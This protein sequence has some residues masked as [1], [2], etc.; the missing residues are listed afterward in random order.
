M[1]S[2]RTIDVGGINVFYREAGSADAPTLLLLHGFPTS[3]AQYEGLIDRLADRFHLVAPDYPG[4]GRTYPLPGPSTFDGLADTVDGFADALAMQHYS[5]YLFD[6]GAPVGFRLATRHP[7]RVRALVIQNANAYEAG[8][9]PNL[10]GLAPYWEDRAANEPAVRAFL[11]LDSTRAQYLEGVAEPETVNPDHWTLD[12]HFQDLPGRDQVML[13]LIYDYTS[14]VALYPTWQAY[15][16]EHRPPT[17]ITWGANDRYFVADGARA[18]LADVPNAQL[19]LL[20]TG[21]FA[22]ATHVDEIAELIAEFRPARAS[23]A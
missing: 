21:H 14:N 8:I 2:Y 10:A 12:Q 18:Y 16:R 20:D 3:S 5:L 6:F 17:L 7:G 4:F 9:G 1:T 22:L 19:H 15:L 11:T 23:A 13:D